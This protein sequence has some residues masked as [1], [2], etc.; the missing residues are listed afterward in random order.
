MTGVNIIDEDGYT[1][2]LTSLEINGR[3]TP[4]EV[5]LSA[6]KD[7]FLAVGIVAVDC[8]A[9]LPPVSYQPSPE[10]E[11]MILKS[12]V[13]DPAL[14]ALVMKFKIETPPSGTVLTIE[15]TDDEN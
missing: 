9:K 7:P 4:A 2:I 5:F 15:E 14:W 8:P 10:E 3:E 6:Q 11:A 13:V 12:H 1:R